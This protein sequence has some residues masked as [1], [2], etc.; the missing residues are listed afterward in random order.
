[1]FDYATTTKNLDLGEGALL[2]AIPNAPSYY[3]PYGQHI[4][5]LLTRQHLILDLE[6]E[7]GYISKADATANATEINTAFNNFGTVNVGRALITVADRGY[8]RNVLVA[9]DINRAAES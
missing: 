2:A 4:P 8:P 9:E 1:M 7:Q 5:E 3:S 6:A